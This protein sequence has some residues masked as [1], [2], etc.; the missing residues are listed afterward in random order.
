MPNPEDLLAAVELLGLDSVT[1]VRYVARGRAYDPVSKRSYKDGYAP[2]Q[3]FPAHAAQCQH[4]LVVSKADGTYY[5]RQCKM[6]V[7][8]VEDGWRTM[9]I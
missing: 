7:K 8:P 1:D 2:W 9:T 4:R 3:L 6:Y 5:C